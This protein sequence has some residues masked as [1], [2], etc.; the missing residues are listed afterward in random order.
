[1]GNNVH[2]VSGPG[3]RTYELLN[4]FFGLSFQRRLDHSI[5]NGLLVGPCPRG[6]QRQRVPRLDDVTRAAHVKRYH[7][8]NELGVQ[9]LQPRG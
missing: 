2:P 3:I 1:M 5:D 7:Q 6:H 4:E 9:E 8:R